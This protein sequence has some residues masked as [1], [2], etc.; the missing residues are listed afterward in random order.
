MTMQTRVI[1]TTK[2]LKLTQYQCKG[3]GEFKTAE[4]FDISKTM[5]D[6]IISSC[7]MCIRRRPNYGPRAAK[8]GDRLR[9]QT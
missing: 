6:G 9:R 4:H 1:K 3:C 8:H 7:R 2:G 5:S